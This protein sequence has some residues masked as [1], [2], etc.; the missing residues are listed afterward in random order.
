[1]TASLEVRSLSKSFR[2]RRGVTPALEGV[3]LRVEPGE[4]VCLVGASGCGKS[5]LL[6]IIAGLTEQSSGDVLLDGE[7]IDGPGP[8]RGLVFQHGHYG[9]IAAL[10]RTAA[11][12]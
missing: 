1:M 2:T 12:N 3:T 4:F 11:K 6:S 10:P 5:T 8:D 9:S 7:S